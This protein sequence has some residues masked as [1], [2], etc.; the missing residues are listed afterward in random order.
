VPKTAAT[1]ALLSTPWLGAIGAAEP[2]C[3]KTQKAESGLPSPDPAHVI[4]GFC[5]LLIATTGFSAW[6]MSPVT[7]QTGRPDRGHLRLDLRA[8]VMRGFATYG[9][10][11]ILGKIGNNIVA[12]YQR[13]IFDI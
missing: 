11:V 3:R 13:R 5:F 7:D 6:V 8:F 9:Q 4:A 12:R 10:A 1:T 2:A